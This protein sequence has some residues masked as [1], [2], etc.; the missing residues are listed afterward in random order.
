MHFLLRQFP[1]PLIIHVA[2]VNGQDR[3]RLEPQCPRHLDLAGLPFGHHRE[4]GQVAIVVQ[5]QVQFDRALG[6]PEF[7]PVE[8]A[9]RQVDD[10]PIQAHQLVLEAEF[11]PPALVA[12]QFLAFHQ[13][14]LKQCLVEFPRP[15]LISVGQGGFL[16]RHGHP[17][18]LQLP[19]ATCQAATNLAQGM[20]PPQLAKQHRQELP[21]TGETPRVPLGFVFLD[22]L[23]EL[24]ARE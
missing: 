21:P 14:L 7:G 8:H 16:R 10:A 13:R 9:H 11:L 20:R 12:H 6:S 17:Q 18:M 2:A 22:G 5:Q 15:I 23:L 3:A 19:F 1:K 4:R 24:P